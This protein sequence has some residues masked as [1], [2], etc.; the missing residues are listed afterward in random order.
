MVPKAVIERA[1]EGR[2]LGSGFG[3]G[4]T[5][6]LMRHSIEEKMIALKQQKLDLYEAVMRG[7]VRGAGHGVLT[8]ADFD[9]LLSPGAG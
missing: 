3:K 2:A 7:T 6:L 9:F 5:W 4:S 8:R 1:H